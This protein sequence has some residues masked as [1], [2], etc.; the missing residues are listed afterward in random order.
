MS[1]RNYLKLFGLLIFFVCIASVSETHAQE[2][3]PRYETFTETDSVTNKTRYY[4]RTIPCDGKPVVTEI[5]RESFQRYNN[6]S[7]DHVTVHP[8]VDPDEIGS[9]IAVLDFLRNE[10]TKV[11]LNLTKS[12]I[13]LAT[14]RLNSASA[15]KIYKSEMN[16]IKLR[17]AEMNLENDLEEINKAILILI[18]KKIA[19]GQER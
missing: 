14:I 9:M 10:L 13:S 18:H 7:V 19:T 15:K 17:E 5:S 1:A 8:H 12:E 3:C 11:R 6:Q 16:V 4:I 2:D